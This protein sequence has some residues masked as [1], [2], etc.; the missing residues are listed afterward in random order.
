MSKQRPKDKLERRAEREARRPGSTVPKARRKRQGKASRKSS[1]VIGGISGANLVLGLGAVLLVVGLIY[2]VTQ[3]S[4]D[5]DSGPVDFQLAQEDADPG[6]PGVFFPP[7]P[8]SDGILG[9]PDDRD[10]HAQGVDI[11]ICTQAQIDANQGTNPVCYTSNPP[12]SGPHG[13]RPMAFEI[14]ENPA[15]KENLVHNMEHGGIVVWYNTTDEAI[16]D[17]L[18]EIVQGQINRRRFVVMSQYPGMEADTIALTSWTRLDKFSIADF[19]KERIEDFIS[20]H[21]KRFN[22]EGF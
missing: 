10:H 7:H 6:L 9:T 22:P 8:G 4:S 1:G 19:S 11:P 3:A 2:L 17:Q 5:P 20:E 16:I 12:T 21:H 14:L 18:K 13:D 15:P